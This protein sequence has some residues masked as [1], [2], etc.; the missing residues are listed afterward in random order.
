MQKINI[1]IDVSKL[2]KDRFETNTFTTK[3]GE[4]VAELNAKLVVIEKKEP[5]TI[6]EGDTWT[7]KETHFIAEEQTKEERENQTKT[8]IVGVGTQFFDKN[9][10]EAK[11][12]SHSG[13]SDSDTDEIDL[14]D[15][16]W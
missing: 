12:E 5:R 3:N 4:T 9:G 15:V 6:K 11:N 1:K 13:T 14:K 2:T 7:L 16:P 8:K 10:S